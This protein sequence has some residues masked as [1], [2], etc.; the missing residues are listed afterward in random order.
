ML[1]IRGYSKVYS[2]QGLTE[3]R[4][5]SGLS[6]LNHLTHNRRLGGV[7]LEQHPTKLLVCI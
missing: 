2:M 5:E 3:Q 1:C 6:L 7:P 4:D